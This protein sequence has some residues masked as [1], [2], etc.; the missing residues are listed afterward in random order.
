M[1]DDHF[2]NEPPKRGTSVTPNSPEPDPRQPGTVYLVGSGPGDPGLL[3]WRGIC[4]LQKADVV[5]YDYLSNPE[6]L[7]YVSPHAEQHCLGSHAERK[8]W[9]QEQINAEMVAHAQQGKTVVRLK[10]GDPTVFARAAEEFD[11]LR[12]HGIPFQIVPGITAALAASAYAGIPLTHSAH[13]SAVA[14]VTGHEKPGKEDS[15]IDFGALASFHG[16]LVFY[17]GVTTA[18]QWSGQLIEHGMSA[19]TPCAIVRRCSWPDQ[20]TFRCTLGELPS[21]LHSGS[22]IRPPVITVVGEVA[23][24]RSIPNWFEQRPLF[25]QSFLVTRPEHQAADLQH[26]LSELGADVVLQPSIAIGPPLDSAPL[27]E[28][29][30]NLESYAWIVFSSVNGVTFFI[31]RLQQLGFDY[32]KLGHVKFAAIGPGTA[33]QLRSF[34]FHTDILPDEYRAESL[35]DALI[36]SVKGQP[37]LL[38]RASRGRDI[39]PKGLATG[40]AK[41]TQA[42]AYQS[43]DV[44]QPSAEVERRLSTRGIDWIIVTSSAIARATAS[45]VPEA[46]QNSKLV[47]ISPITSDTLR[48]LGYEPTVEAKVYTMDGI[49]EAILAYVAENEV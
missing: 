40:G 30:R 14:F 10:C 11:A 20:E 46:M 31:Q 13:A 38:I 1:L 3:T 8:L 18:P 34:G 41:V 43:D 15:A 21:L 44:T 47:S 35:V 33:D 12:Q 23:A 7:G 39:L 5:L 17:M 9:T 37:V 25:G 22:K 49:V 4:C 24:D 42:I 48:D 32:R 6:L 36:D 45:L 29:I 2:A 28:A 16:T 27:D 19:D 26:K